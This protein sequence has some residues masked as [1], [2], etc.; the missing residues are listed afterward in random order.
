M[1]HYPLSRI[2]TILF[3]LTLPMRGL[4]STTQMYHVHAVR[5]GLR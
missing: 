4:F 2:S 1:M 3:L 5:E